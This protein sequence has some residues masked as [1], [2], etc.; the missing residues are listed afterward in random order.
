MYKLFMVVMCLML[1]FVYLVFNEN[2][3]GYIGIFV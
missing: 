2:K 1:F 3:F